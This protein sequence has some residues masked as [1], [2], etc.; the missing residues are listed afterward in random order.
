LIESIDLAALLN[1]ATITGRNDSKHPEAQL[2]LELFTKKLVALGCDSNDIPFLLDAL[3]LTKENELGAPRKFALSA[4]VSQGQASRRNSS[5]IKRNPRGLRDFLGGGA[6][7]I[8]PTISLTSFT[9]SV[10]RYASQGRL[11]EA[12]VET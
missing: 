1:E 6:T 11:H 10:P 8:G 4:S 5:C 12:R 9:N 3:K 2:N 7:I